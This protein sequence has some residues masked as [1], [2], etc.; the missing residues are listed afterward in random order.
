MLTTPGHEGKIYELG[1]DENLTY[2]ELA[3]VISDVSGKPVRFQNV[4]E[5]DYANALQQAGLDADHAK[6]IA[7]ADAGIGRGFLEVTSGD[8]QK[9]LGRPST[10]AAEVFRAAL[11]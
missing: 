10:P 8:L 6:V 1:G 9:L 5:S 11:A 7:D 4:S 3:Q 2:V